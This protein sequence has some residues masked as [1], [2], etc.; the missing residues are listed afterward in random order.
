M[1]RFLARACA[2]VS[3][4]AVASIALSGCT[5]APTG[6]TAGSCAGILSKVLLT[7][8]SAVKVAT[9]N[10][11]DVPKTFGIPSAP[12]PNCYYSSTATL[13]QQGGVI[14]NETHRTLLYIGLS[15]AQVASVIASIRK[16]VSVAPWTVRFDYGAPVPAPTPTA[17]A[18]ATPTPVASTSSSA[19]WY[20]NFSG[21]AADDKGEMGYYAST[22]VSQGLAVQAG[23]TQAVNV[24]RI[25]TDL[26]QVK[27]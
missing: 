1:P 2:A 24:L 22:P 25:E 14:D 21:G 12:A 10:A 6:E 4:L 17:G 7:D 3:A 8:D 19:R 27:K 13:P 9:F 26:K 5:S 16:T 11:S 23:L 15:D 18:S 20:Y